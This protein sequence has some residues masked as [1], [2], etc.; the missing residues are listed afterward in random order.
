MYLVVFATIAIALISTYTQVLAIEIARIANAQTGIAQA[1]LSWHT[2]SLSMAASIIDTNSNYPGGY[3]IG[4]RLSN[5]KQ[6]GAAVAFGPCPGPINAAQS[7]TT[8]LQGTNF[9]IGTVTGALTTPPYTTNRI[10]S[11][12]SAHT[13]CV[14]L[15]STACSASDTYG[16]TAT[17]TTAFDAKTYEFYSILFRGNGSDYVVTYASPPTNGSS[18]YLTLASGKQLG[19]TTGDLLRQLHNVG[20]P[21]YSYGTVKSATGTPSVLTAGPVQYTIPGQA[22]VPNGAVALVGFPGDGATAPASNPVCSGGPDM[23]FYTPAS[24][25]G[26]N[27]E[28]QGSVSTYT[29]AVQ[30]AGSC[31]SSGTVTMTATL[32]SGDTVYSISSATGWSCSG[33]NTGTLT[34]TR[35]DTLSA[36]QTYPITFRVAVNA[37]VGTQVNTATV[38]GGGETNTSNDTYTASGP[39]WSNL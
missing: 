4:C 14:H 31:P 2:A 37:N 36:N 23:T 26:E 32:A 24:T 39:V 33:I 19:L 34:C 28:Y 8:P 15:P 20:L 29:L 9:G 35:S 11:R 6:P 30:N 12:G 25:F 13:E 18:P 22:K 1:M 10:Y 27:G 17:C 7:P 38:S 21:N 16:C 5:D 3:P